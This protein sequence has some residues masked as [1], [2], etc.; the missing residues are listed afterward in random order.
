MPIEVWDTVVKLGLG[1][2]GFFIFYKIIVMLL[3][4]F[5]GSINQVLE[6]HEKQRKEDRE[7]N[8]ES[9]SEVASA[10]NNLADAHK[11]H[12]QALLKAIADVGKRTGEGR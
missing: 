6:A 1:G 8:R 11:L 12:E 3:K 7:S 5:K 10:V 2:L 9:Q 4:D